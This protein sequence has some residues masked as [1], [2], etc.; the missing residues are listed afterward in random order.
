MSAST[1]DEALRRLLAHEGGYVNH[2]SD[3]GGPT[4]HGI[5]LAA[6][7]AF[8]LQWDEFDDYAP[9][10]GDALL[11]VKAEEAGL[12]KASWTGTLWAA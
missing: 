12:E 5:T 1:Y 4:N 8:K 7:A 3:P 2:P 6:Y 9:M 10:T 11:W